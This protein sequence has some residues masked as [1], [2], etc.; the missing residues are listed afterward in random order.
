MKVELLVDDF[1]LRASRV[2]PEKTAIV[3]G[4]LRLSYPRFAERASRLSN[5]LLPSA[6]ARATASAC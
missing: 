6:C 2:Y 4:A 1:L 5:G 3:D